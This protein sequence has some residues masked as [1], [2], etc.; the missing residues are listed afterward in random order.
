M[1]HVTNAR[2]ALG[3]SDG[4]DGHADG[5]HT[6]KPGTRGLGKWRGRAPGRK[7]LTC[8]FLHKGIERSYLK[9]SF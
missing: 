6:H 7:G 9:I 8:L 2:A 1:A 4:G 5:A 3:Q